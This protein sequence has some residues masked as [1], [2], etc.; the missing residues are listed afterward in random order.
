[1]K[2]ITKKDIVYLWI[3]ILSFLLLTFVLS[4]T[5]YLYGSQLDWYA[6]HASIPD[7]FRTLFYNTKELFPDFAMHL[8][9]GQN[10]YN[11]SYYGLLSPM[12]FISYLLPGVS[13]NTFIIVSTIITVIIS[14]V[15]MYVY[16]KGQKL[17]SETCLLATFAFVASAPISFH[18]HR[19]IMF[20]NYMPFLILG[21]FG[22]DRKIKDNKSGLL[23]ISV[24]LMVMTSYYFSISGIIML[25]LF[26][27]YKYLK[28][29]NSFDIKL[30]FKT[31]I[32]FV[33]PIL[34]G[35]L[36][37][38]IIILPTFMTLLNN[39]AESNVSI[40][41]FKLLIPTF[42]TK[43]ILYNA[44]GIG[45][46]A[47]ILPAIINI[48]KKKK[49]NIFLGVILLL[50]IFF[51][52][53]NYILNGT[54]YVDAKS[55]IPFLPIYIYVL[56]LFIEDIFNKKVNYKIMIPFLIG[57][58]VLVFI[59]DY[60]VHRVITDLIISLLLILIYL[61]TNKKA[62]LVF[63]LLVLFSF[64]C[65]TTNKSD[66]LVLKFTSQS[67]EKIVKEQIKNITNNDKAFYRISNNIDSAET[68]NKNYQNINYYNS[69][70]YSSI[71]NQTYNEFYYDVM[72]NN[73]PFRN[74]ALT[75]TTQNVLSL[76][77][78]NNKYIVTREKPLQGYELINTKDGVHTYVNENVMPFGYATSEII[79]YEDFEKLNFAVK[80]EALLNL[81]VVDEKSNNN[82]V[83]GTQKVSVDIDKLLTSNNIEYKKIDNS[84]ELEIKETIKMK[85][86][87]SKE[88]QNKIL[89]IQLKN[90]KNNSCDQTD[91]V[92]KIN[93]VKNKLTCKEWKYHNGNDVFTYVIADKEQTDLIITLNEGLYNIS[94]IEVYALDYAQIE[95]ANKKVDKLLIDRDETKGDKIVGNIDV[96]KDGYLV[97]SIPYDNGFIFKIDNKKVEYEKINDA[98]IGVKISKGQH[99][100][101]VEYKAPFK[102]AG[103]FLSLIGIICFITIT[104]L[105]SKR[106][107]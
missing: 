101:E 86:E 97:L 21:L 75:V 2:N 54:M 89:F 48:F 100:I 76:M 84:Y 59:K 37:A 28:S 42:N 11:F 78:T 102:S 46:T 104:V 74:R 106:K 49:E 27:V 71:S 45:V 35:V 3:I 87:L 82:F 85:H 64:E 7:Y 8:G 96:Q 38:S 12:I 107:I 55:L 36:S 98:F 26:G 9:S 19:H 1:M 90:N 91:Q 29:I 30:F 81:V 56:A 50:T 99:E 47:I 25:V 88:Y 58:V 16:L 66:E 93:N 80:Q 32:N 39:R 31:G 10:I 83:T 4:N 13:M 73:I 52:V 70:I 95:N 57:I 17:S 79:S 68:V 77:L 67:D 53:F 33:I 24:F 14:A 44:Y 51:P 94:D 18:S 5:M 92:I 72:N 105:E 103:L 62:L 20:M 65:Y 34:V 63:G 43:N 61:K 22:V 41:V 15:L 60:K 6:Q 40:N 23:M 69:T